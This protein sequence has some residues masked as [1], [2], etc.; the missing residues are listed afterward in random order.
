MSI[1]FETD[2][3]HAIQLDRNDPLKEFRKRFYIENDDTIYADGN[4]LGRLPVKTKDLVQEVTE[5]QWGAKL[6][7]SWNRHW[8]EKSGML[9]DKIAQII[10]AS[11]GEVIVTDSTSVNLYKLA[12]AAIKFQKDKTRIVSDAFNFP[13]DLY[14]LQGL[15]K[16]AGP[17]H[18]L[19]LA[20]SKDGITI[21][22]NDLKEKIN[23]DTSLVVLSM[24]SFKSSFLY[25]A[26]EITTFAH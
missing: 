1:S 11:E 15:V 4:S 13:T 16:E 5:K 8:Y 10:G 9:G 26:K 21:D 25:N 24:V 19:A 3:N 7:E 22:M 14:I 18:E 23:E 12:H 6:I 17:A 20:D 2:I